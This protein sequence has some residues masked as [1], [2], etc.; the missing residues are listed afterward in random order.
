MDNCSLLVIHGGKIQKTP[1]I[2]TGVSKEINSPT[3]LMNIDAL[4]LNKHWHSE[5]RKNNRRNIYYVQ[6]SF[7]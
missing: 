7:L 3:T 5:F 6:I 4:I 2:K 1:H